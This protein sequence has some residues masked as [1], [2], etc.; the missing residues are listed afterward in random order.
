MK[1]YIKI[2]TVLGL[3]S[4]LCWNNV[5]GANYPPQ[6]HGGANLTLLNNDTI[7]GIHTN[8]GTFTV[9]SGAIVKISP[10]NGVSSTGTGIAEIH[11]NSIIINGI[12]DAS[13]SGYTGGGGGGGGGGAFFSNAAGGAPG[14][15]DYPGFSGYSGANAGESAGGNGGNG[16]RGDGSF[17]GISGVGGGGGEIDIGEDYFQYPTSGTPGTIGG[18]AA[19][20]TNG[21]ISTDSTVYMG[22]GGGGAGGGGGCSVGPGGGYPGGGGGGG[23][24]GGGIIRLY[25]G[26]IFTMTSSGFIKANGVYGGNAQPT[27]SGGGGYGGSVSPPQSGLEGSGNGYGANGSNGGV[28][29]GGGIFL[30]L[31]TVSQ[32]SIQ[33]GATIQSFGGDSSISNGGTVKVF[34]YIDSTDPTTN[35]DIT[36][37]RVYKA[38][39]SSVRRWEIFDQ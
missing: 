25:P 22:S 31:I 9:S 11:A 5:I 16:S 36:A 17:S 35:I 1:S 28:G 6:D 4:L 30:N 24:R 3:S 26:S 29:A 18:Y 33:S 15:A 23:G 13:G 38:V 19:P 39:L 34:Y 14:L 8:I 10:Y 37:G 21:D 20:S 32:T 2:L 27:A 12:L 7:W